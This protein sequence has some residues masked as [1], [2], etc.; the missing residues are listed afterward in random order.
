VNLAVVRGLTTALACTCAL[1]GCAGRARPAAPPAL[2]TSPAAVERLTRDLAAA[3]QAPGVTRA[4]WGILVSSLDRQERLFELNPNTLMVPASSAKLLSV[5][6]AAEAV[7]WDYRFATTMS[8]GGAILDGTERPDAKVLAGDI[9]ISGSGDP[10][11]GGRAGDN[12]DGFVASIR[13]MGIAA[14]QGRII[15]DDD[16][17]EEPRPALAWAWDDLGYTSGTLYGALNLAENR[18]T[19]TVAPGQ[20]AGAPT[21]ITTDPFASDRPLM[22]RALTGAPGS[23]PQ[24]WPE[25]RPGEPFLTIAG[26]VPAGATPS[27]LSVAV[28]NPTRWFASVFRRKLIEAG[29]PVTS[30]A[31]D[32]DDLDDPLD[33]SAL[34]V[35]YVHR[36][37][38]LADI[39]KPLLKDSVNVYAE[40]VMRLNVP[41]GSAMTNDAALEGFRR[42]LTSW[43]IPPGGEQLV[44]G[45]GLSRRDVVAPATLVTVLERMHDRDVTSPWMSA[46][47]VA[48]V[49]G[50]LQS[51]MR[52]TPAAGNV[53]AKTGT[54]SNVRSLSGYVTT[55]D[56]ERLAFAIILNNFEGTAAQATQAV[57]SIAIR[58]AG[59]QR[60]R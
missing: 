49:D 17:I 22:N 51:R 38:T 13:S 2:A 44:D 32:I 55:A 14:V 53:R 37:R 36:S 57:D 30:A 8:I 10:S 25:Q 45:S 58:L 40:A 21:V 6:T 1:A 28:G 9:V 16:A 12:L 4:T 18:M 54:M 26:S 20:D 59:F 23:P 11:I 42:R 43:G 33:R 56:G 19:V 5:A 48:G 50:S 46:L 35:A 27:Q 41:P 34:A 3:T 47:P 52:G 24:L 31:L 60:D 7:G 29:I 39:V 15:G